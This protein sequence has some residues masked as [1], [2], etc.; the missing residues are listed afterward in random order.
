MQVAVSQREIWDFMKAYADQLADYLQPQNC[1]PNSM[2]NGSLQR[3]N[4]LAK[5]FDYERA[6]RERGPDV[7][8]IREPRTMTIELN[9]GEVYTLMRAAAKDLVGQLDSQPYRCDTGTAIKR[10]NELQAVMP[11][12][13]APDEGGG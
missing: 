5:L 2:I 7:Y 12:Y 4:E 10:L 13:K 1:V 8:K 9:Q 3:L 6:Q 11:P